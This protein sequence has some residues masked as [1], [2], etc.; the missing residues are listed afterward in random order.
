MA[1]AQ[2]LSVGREV[3]SGES[4]RGGAG[5]LVMLPGS[6]RGDGCPDAV[7]ASLAGTSRSACLP[8]PLGK[9]FPKLLIKWKAVC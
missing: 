7:G 9:V 2:H 1:P 3:A 6:T 8:A 5:R 4:D